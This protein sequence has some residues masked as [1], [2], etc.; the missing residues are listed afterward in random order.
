MPPI[1][2]S[3]PGPLSALA[4]HRY[5]I[6]I[7]GSSRHELPQPDGVVSPDGRLVALVGGSE[8][9]RT[10]EVGP[11]GGASTSTIA[12]PGTN[13]DPPLIAWSPD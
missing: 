1:V 2:F 10:V 12:I 13:V 11:F 7:D 9:A 3:S 6:G 8:T 5:E 4:A